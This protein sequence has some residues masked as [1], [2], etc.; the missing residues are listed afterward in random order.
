[1]IIDVVKYY[2]FQT[3]GCNL[4]K[5]KVIDTS[6]FYATSDSPARVA[7]PLNMKERK[8][9]FVRMLFYFVRA[10]FILNTN[11]KK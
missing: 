3:V 4:V 2:C 5:M 1:M 9:E 11:N 8:K 6:L 10:K 7:T